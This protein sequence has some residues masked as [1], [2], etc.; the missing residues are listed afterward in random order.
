MCTVVIAIDTEWPKFVT[1]Y[2]T[3]LLNKYSY[4]LAV[5]LVEETRKLVL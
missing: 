5:L 1:C 4:L 3:D 2:Y